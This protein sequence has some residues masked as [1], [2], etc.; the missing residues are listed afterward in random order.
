MAKGGRRVA[1][2]GTRVREMLR[3][4]TPRRSHPLESRLRRKD[5]WSVREGADGKGPALAPRQPPTSRGAGLHSAAPGAADHP[6]CASAWEPPQR[7]KRAVLTAARVRQAFPQLLLTLDTPANAP[8][9]CG[10]SPGRPKVARSG[11]APRFP[12]FKKAA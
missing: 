8:K 4:R 1:C 11:R 6:G 7:S 2:Q 3:S 12:A 5:A 9:P 10:R